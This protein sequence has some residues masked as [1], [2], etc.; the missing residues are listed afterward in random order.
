MDE[1]IKSY[2][3]NNFQYIFLIVFIQNAF[4]LPIKHNTLT[5]VPH[6]LNAYYEAD[7]AQM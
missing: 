2:S 6:N 4:I 3:F 5:G 7:A 1:L